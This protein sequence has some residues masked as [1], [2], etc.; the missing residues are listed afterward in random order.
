MPV[1]AGL[2]VLEV[3]TR[4]TPALRAAP[5]SVAGFVGLTRRGV[6]GR[7]V[8]LT[9]A[10][11]F[12]D[13]FGGHWPD[14]YLPAAVTGFY[15]N[16]GRT[17]HVVRV[18]GAGAAAAAVTLADRH[19]RPSLRVTAG[20]R[21]DPDPGAWAAAIRLDVRDDPKA[22]TTVTAVTETATVRLA[23][24]A[25]IE[26]GSVLRLPTGHHE[27]TA[28]DRTA[29]TVT[30][31]G[32][33]GPLAP[34]VTV[35]TAEF[36]LVVRCRDETTGEF[37]VVEDWCGLAMRPGSPD[38]VVERINHPSTGSRYVRVAGAGDDPPATGAGFTLAGGADG[39]PSAGDLAIGLS[40]LDTVSV[41]L[42]AVPDAHLF[43]DATAQIARHAIDYCAARGDCV[44]VGSA[45]DRADGDS[46]GEYVAAIQAYG[47]RFHTAYGALYA[48]WLMVTDP[49]STGDAPIRAVPPDGHVL[50][51]YARTEQE[52]GVFRSPAGES[53]TIRGTLA[54]TTSFNDSQH[55]DLV[56]LGRV[57][58]IRAAGTGM[59]FVA[60]SRTLS[61]DH[62]WLSVGTRLLFNFVKTTLRD[63]LRFV[64]HEPHTEE[65]RRAV[66]LHVV[67]PFLLGLWRQAAFGYGTPSQA[68]T[69]KCD[70]ENNPPSDVD[71]GN[72]RVEVSLYPASPAETVHLVVGQRP[73]GGTA[74]EL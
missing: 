9:G 22:T 14:S 25:G 70:A 54:L 23:S 20:Y 50:G 61:T 13:R 27:V 72:F 36:R 16:G 63:G 24:L 15:G 45:P 18:V 33:P 2:S 7:P 37:G 28:A 11:Q 62:R 38:H 65:L 57:N 53:A 30:V 39:T 67:T 4:V 34:G 71:S 29:R 21:G 1:Q 10:D 35:T 40:A 43:P 3:Y 55:D 12:A 74:A 17:G 51:V 60:A 44:Y 47:K 66:R 48:P 6:P 52:R 31:A 26:V 5:T 49:S 59:P 64:R 46:P 56:K 69:V 42:V 58:G 68:F 73:T 41:Q 8:R 19:L 32:A